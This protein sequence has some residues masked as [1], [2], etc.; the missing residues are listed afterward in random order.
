VRDT[1]TLGSPHLGA[2][3]ERGVHRLAAQ[4]ARLPETR[5][6]ARLLT[7][8]SVG[9]MDLRHGTLVEADWTD[10]DLDPLG[11]AEH[12]YVPLHDGARHFVVPATLS[13]DPPAGWR[14]C[15]VTYW[16]RRAAPAATPGTTI[17]WPSRPT[18]CTAWAT[19]T[20]STC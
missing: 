10:R 11:P 16:S 1:V 3:L 2:P 4:L 8:R 7:L 12:T 18:T 17:A 9:I 15:S 13:R 5:P 6:L 20:T 19:C 14:T